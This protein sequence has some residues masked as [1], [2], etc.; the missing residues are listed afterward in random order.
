MRRWTLALALF[1]AALASAADI[2]GTYKGVYAGGQGPP[3][4]FRLSL[5]KSNGVWKADVS[6]DLREEVKA[7]TISVEVNG[8]GI[9]LVYQFEYLGSTLESI[10]TGELKGAAFRGRFETKIVGDG[11]PVDQGQWMAIRQ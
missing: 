3:D 8:V 6:F 1:L 2:A 5:S 4:E 11:S 9:K 10:T 7:R